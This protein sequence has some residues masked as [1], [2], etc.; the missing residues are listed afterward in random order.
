MGAWGTDI[1]SDDLACD[2]RR[3]YRNLVGDGFVG[4]QA[5]EILLEEYREILDDPDA[6]PAFWLVFAATKWRYRR[7]EP[8]MP[9]QA[10]ETI[11]N[12]CDLVRRQ[13]DPQ[14]FK[15]RQAVLSQLRIKSGILS[16]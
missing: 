11:D 12:G 10:I 4:Q 3:R 7:L 16:W 15:K 13:E 8:R 9:V 2:I 5:T 1:F 14:L 6:G